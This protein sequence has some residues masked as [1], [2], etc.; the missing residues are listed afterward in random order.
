MH[1]I[2]MGLLLHMASDKSLFWSSKI[3]GAFPP[4]IFLSLIPLA[5][6]MCSEYINRIIRHLCT[7][8][9]RRS[10]K[11]VSVDTSPLLRDHISKF[12]TSLQLSGTHSTLPL[13][14]HLN[15]P[16]PSH[17]YYNHVEPTS[18]HHSP[19][20]QLLNT[21]LH[22]CQYLLSCRLHNLWLHT[23]SRRQ[24]LLLCLLRHLPGHPILPRHKI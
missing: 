11:I 20:N 21:E 17:L 24:C 4:F 5:V 22:Q 7:N 19:P 3:G 2:I 15:Q 10:I 23:N 6:C 16:F 13:S 18:T 8:V 14:L 12:H 1:I 9:S